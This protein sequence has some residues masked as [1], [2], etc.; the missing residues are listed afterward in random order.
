MKIKNSANPNKRLEI[1]S[2]ENFC[3][4]EKCRFCGGKTVRLEQYIKNPVVCHTR[5]T[6]C[7][8]V[9]YDKVMTQ[10]SLDKH[11]AQYV[12]FS[13][14]SSKVTFGSSERFAKHL[15]KLMTRK[16]L[17]INGG[18]AVYTRFWRWRWKPCVCGCK[19][20]FGLWGM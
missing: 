10:E 13:E 9:S 20:T 11:Y 4:V 15:V 5:C 6:E 19:G 3:T 16:V 2:E 17:Y 12:Y 7:G 1:F 18:G 8:A 14:D